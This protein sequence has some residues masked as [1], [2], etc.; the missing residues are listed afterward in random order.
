[1]T[2]SIWGSD[3]PAREYPLLPYVAENWFKYYNAGEKTNHVEFQTLHLFADAEGAFMNWVRTWN[4]DNNLSQKANDIIPPPIYYASLLGISQV[5]SKMLDEASSDFSSLAMNQSHPSGSLG[6]PLQATSYGGHE[7]EVKLLI[8]KGLNV[9]AQAG[10]FGTALQAALYS[11]H[12]KVFQRL[13]DNHPYV[14]IEGGEYGTALLAAASTG[15]EKVAQLLIERG[16]NINSSGGLFGNALLAASYNGS[17]MLVKML[18]DR[19]ASHD[20]PGQIY[21]TAL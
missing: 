20:A 11:G 15:K 1:M 5:V 18:L 17:E 14:N 8:D 13:L 12:E 7:E 2:P 10:Y 6:Y 3:F 4:V 16:A 21:E 9:N 19:N